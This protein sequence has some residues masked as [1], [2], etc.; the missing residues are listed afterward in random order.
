MTIGA[1]VNFFSFGPL[2]G[3]GWVKNLI[4]IFDLTI[5]VIVLVQK[6]YQFYGNLARFL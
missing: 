1:L 5:Y 6:F 2:C 4:C 3:G